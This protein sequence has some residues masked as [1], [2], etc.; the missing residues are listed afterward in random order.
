MTQE[1]EIFQ[2]MARPE[3]YPHTVDKVAERE[4]HI[5]K[6]F[7][8]GDYVYKIK[9]AVDLEFLDYTSLSKRKFYCE[10][11]TILNRRLT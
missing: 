5:S 10:Q 6:V 9:K 7:L 8:T 11:E 3:F 2:A 4:T 1:T